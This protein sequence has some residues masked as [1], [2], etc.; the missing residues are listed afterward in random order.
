ME[1]LF[2]WDTEKDDGCVN[3]ILKL[4]LEGRKFYLKTDLKVRL[5]RFVLFDVDFDEIIQMWKRLQIVKHDFGEETGSRI[6]QQAL[7]EIKDEYN[8]PDVLETIKEKIAKE[9]EN[10]NDDKIKMI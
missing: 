3:E 10:F 9:R 4:S 1:N 8:D 5:K 7:K 6:V 2:W